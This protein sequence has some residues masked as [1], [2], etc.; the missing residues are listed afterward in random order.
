[1][2]HFTRSEPDDIDVVPNAGSPPSHPHAD[3]RDAERADRDRAKALPLTH[4][5]ALLRYG[6]VDPSGQGLH[7]IWGAGNTTAQAWRR[8]RERPQSI[9]SGPSAEP[10]RNWRTNGFSEENILSASPASTIRPRHSSAM[11]S[12]ICRAEAMSWV[13]TM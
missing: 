12:P 6:P 4:A 10:L 8:R 9:V 7:A 11:Y 3:Q 1:M 13:T 5:L 2:Q